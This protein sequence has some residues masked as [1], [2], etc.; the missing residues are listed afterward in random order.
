MVKNIIKKIK[1]DLIGNF[2]TI[3][4]QIH[5]VNTVYNYGPISLWIILEIFFAD[6]V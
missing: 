1:E 3:Q 4:P 2:L 5:S 6:C